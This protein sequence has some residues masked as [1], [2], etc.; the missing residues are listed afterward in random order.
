[1][2]QNPNF[3]KLYLFVCVPPCFKKGF[4]VADQ[5]TL[6]YSKIN[7]RQVFKRKRKLIL[8]KSDVTENKLIQSPQ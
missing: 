4:K 6:K 2:V 5:K 3:T 7:L 1:M 8:R